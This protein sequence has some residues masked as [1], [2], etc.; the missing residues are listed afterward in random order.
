M[1]TSAREFAVQVVIIGAGIVG[2]CLA[3]EVSQLGA[4]VTVI[5]ARGPASGATGRSFGWVNASFYAD[6]P[7]FALRRAGI[8]SYRNLGRR[9]NLKSVAWSGC[10]CWEEQGAAF[11]LQASELT[12]LGYTLSEVDR[13]GFQKMEPYVDPPNR[14]LHFEDEAA[15][16]AVELTTALLAASN[17]RVI[18]GCNVERIVTRNG[19]A[20]GVRIVGGT[21]RADRVIVA[22][23][24]GSPKLLAQVGVEL[25]MLERPGLIMRSRPVSPILNHVLVAPNQEFRQ[26]PS[27]H[28]LAPTVASHQ[29]DDN[30]QI[31]TRPDMLAD[32]ALKRLNAL[33]PS[34]DLEWEEVSLAQ[35]PVPKDGLPV[36]GACGPEGL[37]T[38]VMHS[39]VTLA[40]IVAQILAQDIMGQ[41]LSEHHS[42]LII[43]YRPGRFQS[44]QEKKRNV[45]T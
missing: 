21:V 20:V 6:K 19:K 9:L 36:V 23:G 10:L 40:P 42:E 38:A 29:R 30:D 45:S 1:K 4:N 18:S 43:H 26:L 15:V 44:G 41:M 13:A 37:F 8:E 22:S 11:D 2:A 16:D 35:R 17:A 39:G 3:F 27:G 7:H 33:I 14:A 24:N 32:I 28:I 31:D 25:P 12:E 34:A 5:D